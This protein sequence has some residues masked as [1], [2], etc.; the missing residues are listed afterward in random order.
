[1]MDLRDE[2]STRADILIHFSSVNVFNLC[3]TN[4]ENSR[5]QYHLRA[6]NKFNDRVQMKS[7]IILFCF[8]LP[9]R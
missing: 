6:Q 7:F 9:V 4:D 1:M 8:E 2:M 5:L 3:S